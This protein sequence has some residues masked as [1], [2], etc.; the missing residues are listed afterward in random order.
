[1]HSQAFQRRQED[2]AA[3]LGFGASLDRLSGSMRVL[4]AN[5][6][7]GFE[8]LRLALTA[9]ALRCRHGRAAPR[10]DRRRANQADQRPAS[11][12][13]RTLMA[14]EF[15]GPS[16]CQRPRGTPDDLKTITPQILKQ[17]A[18]ALLIARAA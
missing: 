13:A 18:A 7:E 1:M 3:S 11:V 12:A 6:D 9:A 10:P 16:L 15:A 2:A 17:R 8:L 14:A 4:S 5:R